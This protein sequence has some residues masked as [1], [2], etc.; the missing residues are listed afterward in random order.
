MHRDSFRDAAAAAIAASYL[1]A[2]AAVA[3]E[4][5]SAAA[6]GCRDRAQ[7]GKAL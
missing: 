4:N 3:I 5:C 1:A 2:V 6:D 7:A